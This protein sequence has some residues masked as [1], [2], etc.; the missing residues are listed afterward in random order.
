MSPFLIAEQLRQR[1]HDVYAVSER[2]ELRGLPDATLLR[3]GPRIR[4]AHRERSAGW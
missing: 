3:G 4:A 1:D 2:A